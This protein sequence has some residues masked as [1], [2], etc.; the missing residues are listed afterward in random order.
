MATDLTEL[1]TRME[2]VIG[3]SVSTTEGDDDWNLRRSFLNRAQKVWSERYDWSQLLVEKNQLTSLD[4]AATVGLP[5]DFRKMAGELQFG[6]TRLNQIDPTERKR[7]GISD[8]YYY[9]LGEP[10]NGYNAV[11]NPGTL[12][13]GTSIFYQYYRNPT[14]LVSGS[15]VSLCPNPDYLI[16][17]GLYFY[18][19][20]NEDERFQD[21]RAEAERILANMLEFENVKSSSYHNEVLNVDETKYGHRW[22]R[23]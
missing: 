17:Q 11:V 8:G 9:V 5:T 4:S 10:S 1:Q 23:D 21:A 18:F 20:A 12:A 3:Q 14:S 15:D 22:G 19:L 2:A 13:S 6:T 16:Q 7:F